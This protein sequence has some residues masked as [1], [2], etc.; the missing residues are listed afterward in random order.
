MEYHSLHM[1]IL[2]EKEGFFSIEISYHDEKCIITFSPSEKA[3]KYLSDNNLSQFIKLREFQ[4]RKLLHNKRPQSYY[5]GFTLNFVLHDG[6]PDVSFY[7]RNK[8]T[9]LNNLE[10]KFLVSKSNNKAEGLTELFT[11]GSYNQELKTGGYALIIKKPGKDLQLYH[12]KTQKKGNNLIELLA[13]IK[14]LEI[15][16]DEIKLRIITDS[17][18]VIKGITEWLPLWKINN[19]Y[20]ANG[21]K[22]KNI[23]DWKK[24]DHLIKNRY[25]EFEWVKSHS[26][27]FENT[28]CDMKAKSVININKDEKNK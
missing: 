16:K 15:L 17:Q 27:H 4:L 18:Y 24:V 11:D 14:G 5:A 9:V 1:H 20:T 22:A 21:T 28:I 8:I 6:L 12:F 2:G 19:F 26:E 10:N 7:D 25:I 23:G 3:I 13:I